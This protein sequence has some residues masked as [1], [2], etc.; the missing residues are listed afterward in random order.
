MACWSGY[1][2]CFSNTEMLDFIQLF[3]MVLPFEVF[4]LSDPQDTRILRFNL[5]SLCNKEDIKGDHDQNGIITITADIFSWWILFLCSGLWVGLF[6]MQGI[7][8]WVYKLFQ[9]QFL[10][11]QHWNGY[12]GFSLQCGAQNILVCLMT[13]RDKDMSCFGW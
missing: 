6:T 13:V 5:L 3:R 8:I 1:T 2:I 7:H 11:L 10:R 12:V 9:N 4:G